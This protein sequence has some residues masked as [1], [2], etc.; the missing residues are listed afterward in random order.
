MKPT[1]AN[2]AKLGRSST[3]RWPTLPGDVAGCGS[4]GLVRG[5]DRR[6]PN[7]GSQG[8]AVPLKSWKRIP[9]DFNPPENS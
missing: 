5:L 6:K 2:S 4:S 3:S 8:E 1:W 7:P 9:R